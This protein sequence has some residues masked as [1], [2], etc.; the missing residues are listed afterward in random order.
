MGHEQTYK[1]MYFGAPS[2]S[3]F[4]PSFFGRHPLWVPKCVENWL[5]TPA[6]RPAVTKL[7][8]QIDAARRVGLWAYVVRFQRPSIHRVRPLKGPSPQIPPP[9]GLA[10]LITLLF[11]KT[12]QGSAES[13]RVYRRWKLQLHNYED[14]RALGEAHLRVSWRPGS[15]APT[16]P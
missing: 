9:A 1:F 8:S 4:R 13:R 5:S 10:A 16:G 6:P 12:L 7:S 15:R 2:M 11:G 14:F 3:N